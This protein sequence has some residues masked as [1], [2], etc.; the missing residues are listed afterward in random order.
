MHEKHL[1]YL[2]LLTRGMLRE[3][4]TIFQGSINYKHSYTVLRR[5]SYW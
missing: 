2:R 3:D 4:L 5:Y 1:P